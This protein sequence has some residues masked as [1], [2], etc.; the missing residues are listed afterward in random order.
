MS[1][2][3]KDDACNNNCL[4]CKNYVQTSAY[5]K[6]TEYRVIVKCPQ[7]TDCKKYIKK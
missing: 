4:N 1:K 2:R 5:A 3:V 7:A 6:C